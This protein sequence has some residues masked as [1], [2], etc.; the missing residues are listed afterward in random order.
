MFVSICH[1]WTMTEYSHKTW[2]NICIYYDV[3]RYHYSYL[4]YEDYCLTIAAVPL[5]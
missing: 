2:K 4:F 1:K 3:L 5:S